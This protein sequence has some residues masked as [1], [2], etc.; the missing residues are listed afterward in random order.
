MIPVAF[1]LTKMGVSHLRTRRG[2]NDAANQVVVHTPAGDAFFSYGVF[3]AFSP[4]HKDLNNTVVL[5][6]DWNY[7]NTTGQYRNQ[8]LGEGVADTRRKIASGEYRLLTQEE[9]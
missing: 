8:F 5:G 3:I 4:A 7:S 9:L 1:E 6:P 2:R